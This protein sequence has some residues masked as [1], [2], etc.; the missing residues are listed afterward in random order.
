MGAA[1]P[2]WCPAGFGRR[3]TFCACGAGWWVA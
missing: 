3:G 1:C 2:P